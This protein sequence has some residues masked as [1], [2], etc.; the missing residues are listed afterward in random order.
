[1]LQTYNEVTGTTVDEGW[2][3]EARVSRAWEGP[4]FDPASIEARRKQVVE[5]GRRQIKP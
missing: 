5:R 2:K 4:G 3:I 1:M